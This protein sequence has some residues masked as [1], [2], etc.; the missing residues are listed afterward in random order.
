M[1]VSKNRNYFILLFSIIPSSTLAAI[2]FILDAG[3]KGGNNRNY[4]QVSSFTP[5]VANE[6]NLL[7]NDIGLMHH[8]PHSRVSGNYK[9][10]SNIYE[11]NFRLG[12]RQSIKDD[13]INRRA[14]FLLR[15]AI[16]EYNFRDNFIYYN[17]DPFSLRK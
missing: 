15:V 9:Y 7:F 1:I 4:G 8:L 6:N 13:I 11:V 3:V 16:N 14:P 12:Y 5:I 10:K 2:P 17:L